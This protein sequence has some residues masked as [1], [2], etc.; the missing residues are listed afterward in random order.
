MDERWSIHANED[1]C[2]IAMRAAGSARVA[3]DE[4]FVAGRI[5]PDLRQA[6]MKVDPDALIRDASEGWEELVLDHGDARDVLA[7]LSE[8]PFPE[9]P[10]YVQ[11]DVARV[12]V[13]AFVRDEGVSLFVRASEAHHLRRRID[14]ERR[15][16]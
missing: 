6:V 5:P 9:P 13:R 11:G 3:A 16:R 14:E 4:V 7:G 12:A 2:D 8:L 15:N 10:G 1:A